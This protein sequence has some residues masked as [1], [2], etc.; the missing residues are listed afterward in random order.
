MRIVVMHL[1]LAFVV[2]GLRFFLI[3]G[4]SVAL[5]KHVLALWF[6]CRAWLEHLLTVIR[7]SL[8]VIFPLMLVIVPTM[9]TV[10]AS[11]PL[12]VVIME[13]VASP[14]VVTVTPM[15]L[16]C[17]TRDLLAILFSEL[18]THLASHT[19]LDLMLAF[20][21]KGAIC[22]LQVLYILEVLGN[23]LNHLV[24]KMSTTLNVLCAIP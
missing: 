19:I 15:T 23:K 2:M 11:P 5:L 4:I 1:V 6:M 9:T 18:V 20:L 7:Q 16:F 13:R 14:T 24:T 21:C 3:L 10:I 17:D 22:H 8:V 12:V